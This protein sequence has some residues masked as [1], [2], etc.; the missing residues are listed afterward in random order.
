MWDDKQYVTD[1]L[2]LPIPEVIEITK[3]NVSDILTGRSFKVSQGDKILI[4]GPTGG[5][6]TTFINAL[7]GKIK[8]V[9][10]AFG[11]PENFMHQIAEF[12]QNMKEKI[13]T[14]KIT[15]RQLFDNEQNN[16]IIDAAL[17]IANIY[18]R[19]QKLKQKPNIR[20]TKQVTL[21]GF[22]KKLIGI[23]EEHVVEH[24]INTN[25]HPYDVYIDDCFSGGEKTRLT[26][27]MVLYDVITN[28]NIKML[29][30]DEPEQGL[31]PEMAYDVI[32]KIMKEF[33]DK[34]I[35]IISHLERIQQK[36]NWDIGIEI[37]NGTM[38]IY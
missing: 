18:D 15:I 20:K 22:I 35:I 9:S 21:M 25:K 5:G 6:K 30:L 24:I 11:V 31:D 28:P 10:L 17:K 32:D 37:N 14:R 34:T 19:S 1:I 4:Q 13:Q 2:N 7:T 27:A 12:S 29:I 26:L 23:K 38:K 3:I 36:Y 33:N 16:E 8:G